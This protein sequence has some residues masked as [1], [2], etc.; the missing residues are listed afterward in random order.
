LEWHSKLLKKEVKMSVKLFTSDMAGGRSEEY[1]QESAKTEQG[2]GKKG[3][4]HP[5]EGYKAEVK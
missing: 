4:S 3:F 2:K 5:T 1:A